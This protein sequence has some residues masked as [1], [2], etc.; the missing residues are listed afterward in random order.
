MTPK[1]P[2]HCPKCDGHLIRYDTRHT[3]PETEPGVV[4]TTSYFRCQKNCGYYDQEAYRRQ[5]PE[6]EMRKQ[7]QK[8][9]QSGKD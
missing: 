8:E 5:M 2:K 9:E 1:T 3:Y 6:E 7:C 4:V